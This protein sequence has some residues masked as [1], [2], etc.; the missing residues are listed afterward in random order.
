MSRAVAFEGMNWFAAPVCPEDTPPIPSNFITGYNSATG[1]FYQ[2]EIV[3]DSGGNITLDSGA[4][5][6]C[7]PGSSVSLL[8]LRIFS[9]NGAAIAGGLV[10]GN[11]YR[12]GGDPDL[13]AVV[14]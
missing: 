13:L 1:E 10:A 5:L 14:H 12:L 3:I 6:V 7:E 2:S 9:N 8:N 11:A 4:S